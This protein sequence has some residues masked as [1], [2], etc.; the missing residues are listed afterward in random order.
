MPPK[1]R[2]AA[3]KA[4]R[5]SKK[6]KSDVSAAVDRLLDKGSSYCEELGIDMEKGGDAAFQWLCAS[7]IFR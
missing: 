6:A 4:K 3:Q 7:I 1:K 5:S 2:Q